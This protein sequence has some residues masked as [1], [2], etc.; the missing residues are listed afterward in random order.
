MSAA[1]GIRTRRSEPD[2]RGLAGWLAASAGAQA[3][4][5]LRADELPGGAVQQHWAL[6][7]VFDGGGMAGRQALVLRANFQTP[8][9]ASRSK[10]AEFATLQRVHAAGLTVPAPLFLCDDDSVIGTPFFV[11]RRLPGS[12]ERAPLLA[13]A[14]R[15]GFGD[16]LGA[17][18]AGELARLHALSPDEPSS[19]PAAQS[20]FDGYRAWL[21]D[22]SDVGQSG[23]AAPARALDWLAAQAPDRPATALVH[24]DFRTGNFL[25]VGGR[26]T[27]ILDWEFAGPGDPAEDIGWLCA[28]C[29]RGGVDA[30]EAGGLTTR[31]T[32]L[33]A[34]EAA[35]G[36]P[37][38]AA[39]IDYWEVMA[40]LRW[41][42]IARQQA[43]RAAAGDTPQHELVE[44][45]GRIAGLDADLLR[46][47][48][49]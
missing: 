49:A 41:A 16:A 22:L 3:A 46:L 17:E 32:F 4:T 21:A 30:R 42:L 9:P 48:G 43:R 36:A 47:V 5:V 1:A 23:I 2:R 45:A 7:V 27:G 10:A 13:A 37:I 12:A 19:G 31:A 26:L 14:A 35:G 29:W 38:P 8:L 11:M 24:R 34:Y 28:R 25:V 39:V 20:L 33:A 40:H 6:D 18:L 44:A 15:D